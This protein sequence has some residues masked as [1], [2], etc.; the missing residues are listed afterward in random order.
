MRAGLCHCVTRGCAPV[1]YIRYCRHLLLF[2]YKTTVLCLYYGC[3]VSF[4]Q[5]VFI[6][7]NIFNSYTKTKYRNPYM[8]R[9]IDS[10]SF[11]KHCKPSDILKS[12]LKPQC[13]KEGVLIHFICKSRTNSVV[14]C[15]L[16]SPHYR[17]L[18]SGNCYI[19][20]FV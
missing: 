5:Y 14:H 20:L 11:T 10:P 8:C 1:L 16:P 19:V 18:E 6:S 7:L 4:P 13:T 2:Y 17:G 3:N 15:C 12:P 9:I